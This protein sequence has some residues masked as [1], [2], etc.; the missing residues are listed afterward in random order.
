MLEYCLSQDFCKHH[1][2]VGLLLQE[3]KSSLN[4]IVQVRK[5]AIST[6]RDL[7]A[8]HELDDRYQNKGQL[9]RIAAI[10]IPFLSVVLEN[11]H[12]LQSVY[13]TDTK[14][15]LKQNHAA[16]RL[17]SSSSNCLINKDQV[18]G[19]GQAE[20]PKSV[21]RFTLHLDSQSPIRA[22]MHLRDSTY[23][24][25]IAGQGLAN[26]FSCTSIESS[27][28]TLSST[29]H[30]L[31]SQET[32]IAREPTENGISEKKGHS[33]S[34]SLAQA[35]SR[36]DKLQSSEMKDLLLCFLFVVKYLGDH[37]VIAWWQQCSETEIIS[38]FSIIEMSLYHF[39]YVGKRLIV[40]NSST[41]NSGK[42]K[43]VKAMTLP[44]R[45][46]P[47]D[48]SNDTSGTGTLQP[49]NTS[50][51]ENLVDEDNALNHQALLEANM[52]TEV[53]L[54]VLDCLGLFCIHFK[55]SFFNY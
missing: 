32:T 43:T 31:V 29:S 22:S 2:L 54:I 40:A 3:V 15:D 38:F 36:C 47:P 35:S 41:T 14:T 18:N 42:P 51:R 44:A 12:R 6:L 23:F 10:Y 45:M 1:F 39:K 9:S 48:F 16:N 25:A 4:E 17:S 27:T 49:H 30:S 33:R 11:L 50:T 28:S 24:A 8:K 37:Q 13:E 19:V 5:V 46:A 55:V 7:L 20:T 53:G 34:V 52:A 21:H 26:G